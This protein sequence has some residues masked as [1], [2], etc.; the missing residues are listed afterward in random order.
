MGW[1]EKVIKNGSTAY[2][3]EQ[4]WHENNVEKIKQGIK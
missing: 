4:E 2:I 3:I 1:R